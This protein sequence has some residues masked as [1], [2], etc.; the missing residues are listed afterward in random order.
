MECG[1]GERI[2][3]M[4]RFFTDEI[5]DGTAWIHG[6]DVRHIR[7]VLRL[8]PGDSVTLCDGRGTDYGAV[9]RS[10]STDSVELGILS[11]IPSE[12]ESSTRITLYQC[13]PKSGKM[14]WI[15]QKGTEL[16]VHSIVPVLSER[17]IVQPGERFEQRRIRYQRV[18]EEAAKQSRRGVIPQ[19]RE[20]IRIQDLVPQEGSLFLVC[21]EEERALTLKQALRSGPVP[22]DIGILIGPE[23]GLARSETKLLAARGGICVTLGRRILRTETAGLAVLAQIL[24]EVEG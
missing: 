17:C 24:F 7:K 1:C 3:L 12:S 10:I 4:H 13:L 22:A 6:E 19:V 8:V 11:S 16:G 21:D 14:E 23:G 20:L 2:E 5:S 18:A 9:I 15:V